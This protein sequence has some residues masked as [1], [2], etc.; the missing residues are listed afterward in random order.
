MGLATDASSPSTCLASSLVGQSTIILTFLPLF[1]LPS[2]S[3]VPFCI[4]SCSNLCKAGIPNASVLPVPVLDRPITSRPLRTGLNADP[5][6]SVNLVIPLEERTSITSCLMPFWTQYGFVVM[7][8][9]GS[10]KSGVSLSS[11]CPFAFAFLFFTSLFSTASTRIV[12][13]FV[14]GEADPAPT[15]PT[16]PVSASFMELFKISSNAESKSS[17]TLVLAWS[18]V[19]VLLLLSLVEKYL[20]LLRE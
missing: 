7:R 5:C 13:V 4:A 10:L 19:L 17:S 14:D 8:F 11:S 20:N 6:T 12:F 9:S 16:D 2:S 15:D 3:T 1:L 18:V